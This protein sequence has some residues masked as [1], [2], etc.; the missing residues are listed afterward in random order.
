MTDADGVIKLIDL[1]MEQLEVYRKL[2][3]VL[4]PKGNTE[5]QAFLMAVDR[6]LEAIIH[7]WKDTKEKIVLH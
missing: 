2:A 3:V 4:V 1:W 6:T 5:S 7:S